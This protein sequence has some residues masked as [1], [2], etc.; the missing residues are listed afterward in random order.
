MLIV[1]AAQ[2]YV[3]QLLEQF[4]FATS[5]A[6]AAVGSQK[7][8]LQVFLS[9][10]ALQIKDILKIKFFVYVVMINSYG[11]SMSYPRNKRYFEFDWGKKLRKTMSEIE[12]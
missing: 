3:L 6:Q 12:I 7:S 1:H 9:S 11:E 10:E 4:T 2:I 8:V 5:A